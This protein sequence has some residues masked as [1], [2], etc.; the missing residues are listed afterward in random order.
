MP[1]Q[2]IFIAKFFYNIIILGVRKDKISLYSYCYFFPQSGILNLSFGFLWILK[3]VQDDKGDIYRITA[4]PH[5]IPKHK[6][7]IS[8][9]YT[10]IAY[11]PDTQ[12]LHIT[13]IH[14]RCI[15]PRYTNIAYHPD[16][17]TLPVILNL[18]QDLSY[19]IFLQI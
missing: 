10:N 5:L 12:T 17:Q 8:P 3:Q 9:R 1:C 19:T 14:K 4:T 18:F 6:H 11:H 16:T 13:Q 2:Y 7:C 15:S